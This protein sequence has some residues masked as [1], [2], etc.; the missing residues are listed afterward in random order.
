MY[1]SSNEWEKY[2][3]LIDFSYISRTKYR[4]KR[5]EKWNERTR[6]SQMVKWYQTKQINSSGVHRFRYS[7]L[8]CCWY[9]CEKMWCD[10]VVSSVLRLWF[11]FLQRIH[12]RQN[13]HTHTAN[14]RISQ[15][16]LLLFVLST[17]HISCKA[18]ANAFKRCEHQSFDY[19]YNIVWYR[20]FF[21]FDSK[22]TF[23]AEF[24]CLFALSSNLVHINNWILYLVPDFYE[25]WWTKVH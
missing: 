7:V 21:W 20:I 16:C 13:T 19:Y 6:W 4:C 24:N 8:V 23:K 5:F 14:A 22:I 25:I 12:T 10:D 11:R 15:I 2:L 9:L 17:D 1:K 18:L 3:F